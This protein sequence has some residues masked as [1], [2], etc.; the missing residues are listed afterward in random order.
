MLSEDVTKRFDSIS[1]VLM[2][3]EGVLLAVG[4]N[5]GLLLRGV[6]HVLTAAHCMDP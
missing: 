1:S 2:G 6:N 5:A 4:V 3:G